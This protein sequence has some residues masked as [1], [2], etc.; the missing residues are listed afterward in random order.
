MEGGPRATAAP[1]AAG[2]VAAL[3]TPLGARHAAAGGWRAACFIMTRRFVICCHTRVHGASLRLRGR[4]RVVSSA[5]SRRLARHLASRLVLRPVCKLTVFAAEHNALAGGAAL[6]VSHMHLSS[7]T[8]RAG[9]QPPRSVVRLR[10]GHRCIEMSTAH[11]RS[12]LHLTLC[13]NTAGLKAVVSGLQRL[14]VTAAQSL[15]AQ[16]LAYTRPE[17]HFAMKATV[18]TRPR[19]AHQVQRCDHEAK[20]LRPLLRRRHKISAFVQQASARY[21][22]IRN[23]S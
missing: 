13:L 5:C 4:S 14:A 17:R 10:L 21:A 22:S 1:G 18:L 11:L 19:K 3:R 20:D 7:A 12:K 15:L 8:V 6:E 9:L 23:V 16:D 2:A